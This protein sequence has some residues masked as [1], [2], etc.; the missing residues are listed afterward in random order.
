V[1]APEAA[2]PACANFRFKARHRLTALLA[3]SEAIA[4]A[5]G[6]VVGMTASG[7]FATPKHSAAA[8]LADRQAIQHSIG[9]LSKEIATLKASIT[10][11]DRSARSPITNTAERLRNAP[12]IT[13]SILLPLAAIPTPTPR[14]AAVEM[15][16]GGTRLVD[17][18]CARRLR[19]CTGPRRRLS[20]ADRRAL[21]GPRLCARD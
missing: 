12:E 16:A 20:G 15:S 4:A 13:G 18:L 11:A 3:A 5:L 7:G 17:P 10:A 14:P 19:L 6:V 9:K 1:F 2:S 21:A 8:S